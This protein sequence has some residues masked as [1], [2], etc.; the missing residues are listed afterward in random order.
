MD[1]AGNQADIAKTI[2]NCWFSMFFEVGE[3][4]LEAFS[5]SGLSFWYTGWQKAGILD[6]GLVV[7][8]ACWRLAGHGGPMSRGTPVR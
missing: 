2:E 1:A 3:L 6:A 4:I 8:A 5:I 7:A